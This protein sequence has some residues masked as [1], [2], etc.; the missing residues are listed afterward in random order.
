MIK[1]KPSLELEFSCPECGSDEVRFSRVSVPGIY[2]LAE[3]SCNK[4]ST[5]FLQSLPVGHMLDH[6]LAAGKDSKKLYPDDWNMYWQYEPFLRS[7]V[8]YKDDPVSIQKVVYFE[9]RKV[10][11][12]NT[13][14][15]LY[16][17]TLLKL[18]N[19]LHYLDARKD[20]GLIVIIPRIFEWMVPKGCAEV[21]IV[22]LRLSELRDG[23]SAIDRFVAE[24][25]T[26]FEE[27]HVSRAYSHPDFTSIDIERLTGVAPFDVAEFY[28]RRPFFT[29]VLR[30]DRWWLKNRFS[31]IAYRVARKFKVTGIVQKIIVRN[32]D[33]L[34]RRTIRRIRR[35]IPEAEFGVT[36]LGK[37]GSLARWAS[38][39]RSTKITT[40]TER[41]WCRMYA[42]SHVVIGAHGS[43]M[44]LPTAHSAGCVEVL[45]EERNRNIMQDLSV[46]YNDRRQL[47]FYRFVDQFASPA[48][49][50]AKVV[51]MYKHYENCYR[52]MVL[53]QYS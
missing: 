40:D 1:I 20:L 3:Y 52:N 18:Y 8:N 25:C 32:Q 36:G 39:R 44:L 46:R 31:Q 49:V 4:C 26:R 19:A 41:E 21:W 13:L 11:I 38:D 48:S 7:I 14:D 27:I 15:Y 51:A 5:D 45:M 23:Y 22:N 43:N 12:L 9:H 50:A 2:W 10:V 34:V 33:A 42:K 53:N 6:P 17:H 29:F 24:E 30:E 28:Q 35:D 37:G 16:G 47:F